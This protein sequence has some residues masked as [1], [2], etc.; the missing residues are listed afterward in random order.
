MNLMEDQ[1]LNPAAAVDLSIVCVNWNSVEYLLECIPSIYEHTR[2]ISFEIIVVDNASPAGD[3]SV[4]K[5]QFPDIVLILSKENLGFAGANNLGVRHVKGEY[6]LFLNPDTKLVSPA[7]TTML[8]AIRSLPDAG[9]VG[10]KLL[11]GDMTIQ[12]SCIMLYPTILSQCF[13]L[14][15]LRLRWPRLCGIGPLFSDDPA[16]AKV[17]AISGACMLM[18][19]EVFERVGMF[20]EDYFMYAEDVDLCYQ[21]ERAGLTNYYVGSATIVHYAG[22]SSAPE[23]QNVMKMKSAVRFCV[24][25]YGRAYGVAFRIAMGF[26]AA[27]RL[28]VIAILSPFKRS[29]KQKEALRSTGSKWIATMKALLSPAGSSK[30]PRV[31]PKSTP[32]LYESNV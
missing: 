6:V 32:D 19:R 20:A 25:N 18:R 27:L 9:V 13:E 12:T 21:A 26:N 2:G 17:Q 28:L 4:L 3:P 29:S 16:P 1:E 22:K 23:W 8:S 24:K 15:Y 31:A 14:E 7:L 30:S 5:Q 11:N 10:C